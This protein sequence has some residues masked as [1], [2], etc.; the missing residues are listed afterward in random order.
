MLKLFVGNNKKP[1]WIL[2]GAGTLVRDHRLA[3]KER[4]TGPFLMTRSAAGK[5]LLNRQRVETLFLPPPL[6]TLN[7]KQSDDRKG[8]L[9]IIRVRNGVRKLAPL[10]VFIE[11][12]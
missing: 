8:V 7:P 3:G 6:S 1:A 9:K 4:N 12:S 5:I 11:L 2:A 10:V